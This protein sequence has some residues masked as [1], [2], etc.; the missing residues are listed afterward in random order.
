MTA[1]RMWNIIGIVLPHPSQPRFLP[2][3]G[4]SEQ[5]TTQRLRLRDPATSSFVIGS[6]VFSSRFWK[7]QPLYATVKD[8]FEMSPFR[9][10]ILADK[11]HHCPSFVS[12]NPSAFAQKYHLCKEME[13]GGNQSVPAKAVKVL[14]CVVAILHWWTGALSLNEDKWFFQVVFF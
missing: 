10:G 1:M 2:Y 8:W 5:W 7:Q 3:S 13:C 11:R 9:S 6:S 14:V 12:S 4:E